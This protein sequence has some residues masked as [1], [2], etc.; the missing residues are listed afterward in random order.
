MESI[1]STNAILIL[2]DFNAH[3]RNDST[4]WKFVVGSNGNNDLNLQGRL[5]L[6]FCSYSALAIMNT[7]FRHKDIHKYTWYKS[8][9]KTTQRSIIDIFAV[10]DN[11]RQTITNVCVKRG[12]ELSTD[13]HLVVCNI[14]MTPIYR[15]KLVKAKTRIRMK[16][17]QL[18]QNNIQRNFCKKIDEKFKQ[19]S[20]TTV[21]IETK[22]G[23][24]HTAI[25]DEATE[26]SGTK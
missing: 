22:W 5:L 6:D 12:A 19:L 7:F 15:R 10:T 23:R 1:P 26:I 25:V 21:D 8:G 16:W 9:D 18:S 20:A 17:E 2:G 4:T 11:L 24:F 3:V 14:K 13:H